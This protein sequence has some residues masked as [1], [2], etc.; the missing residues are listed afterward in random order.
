MA[1]LQSET[2]CYDIIEILGKGTFGEVAKSWKRSSREMV[3]IKILKNDVCRSRI[4]KNEL[5]LLKAMKGVDS[6]ESH[7]VQFYEYFHDEL[8]FYLV[9]ELLEQN[10]FEY[11]KEN[12]FAPL[13][14]RHIRTVTTQVLKA[15]SKLKE[16]S[17]IHADLKP[18]N[19]MIVDQARYPFRVKVIDFGSASIFSEV[20]Y[21]KEPYI[22]SRFYRSPEILL[23]LPFCEKV[24]MWS[25]GCV[26]GELQLGWP[27]YPGNN[28]YDQIRYICETQGMPKMQLLNAASK[29]S[30]F[31]KKNPQPQIG[32][33]WQLKSAA[34]YQAETNVKPLER[35]KYILKSLDQ[36]ESVNVNKSVFP[37][38]EV[39]AEYYDLKNMVELIKRM[40]TWDS[41][42][43]INPNAA[44][45]HPFISMQQLKMNY[46]LTKYYEMSLQCIHASIK[47]DQGILEDNAYYTVLGDRY[48]DEAHDYYKNRNAHTI[49]CLNTV[50]RTIDQMDDL[51]IDEP[52]MEGSM[53][54]WTEGSNIA[55]FQSSTSVEASSIC[56]DHACLH[57]PAYQSNRPRLDHRREPILSYY[58][59]RYGS[60]HRK[61]PH[62]TKSDVTFGNLILL[63]QQ[64][65]GDAVSWEDEEDRSHT[66]ITS[67]AEEPGVSGEQMRLSKTHLSPA[68]EMFGSIAAALTRLFIVVRGRQ[69][70][71]SAALEECSRL[72]NPA[73]SCHPGPLWT[74]RSDPGVPW[75][76][77]E[78]EE[79]S[80][81][82]RNQAMKSGRRGARG[83]G[84]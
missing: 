62:H 1:V 33:Q 17:I 75:D 8:K 15:L 22:Q 43:R 9:F 5:K 38:C 30:S 26:M 42:E 59:S 66:S 71:R 24:D 45:K 64:S 41:H 70:G 2:D 20:R 60:K 27:L 31:F 69:D 40:L 63:G 53:N 35:R 6:E 44:M 18:E 77:G 78:D 58:G 46:E 14:I 32:N 21:V 67:P 16:L 49:S 80:G 25:L 55:A 13:P 28:E 19:I 73:W 10:L 39:L 76:G 74:W 47:K 72:T 51:R 4:I 52:K 23:G 81:N 7:I 29:T 3:A 56:Q 50:Q 61:A 34:E 65:P 68:L 11:Q 36:I 84:A 37:D 83:K 79:S 57:I 82:K 54:M 48:Y 12:N